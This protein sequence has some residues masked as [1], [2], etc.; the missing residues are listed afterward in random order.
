MFLDFAALAMTS[1]GAEFDPFDAAAREW[2]QTHAFEL[3]RGVT[4]TTLNE[5]RRTL[6]EGWEAGEGI[7][8]L[9]D[10]VREV[11]EEADRYRSF[12]IARTET[13]ATGNM[14]QLSVLRQTGIGYKTW[15]TSDDE[16]V[17]PVCGPLDGKTVRLDEEFA[18]GI[19][20]PPA[21][22][23]CRCTT[24][25][26]TELEKHLPGRHDQKTHG[27]HGYGR[28]SKV[29]LLP[30]EDA[31]ALGFKNVRSQKVVLRASIKAKILRN[32]PA[33]A[34]YL[35]R[36]GEVLTAWERQGRSP[37]H[38]G[39]FERYARL[40]GVWFTAVVQVAVEGS[41]YR[42]NFVVTFHRVDASKVA[43]RTRQGRIHP[44]GP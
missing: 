10:R 12:L 2:L 7:P 31:E 33:D 32:H 26:P 23:N 24:L 8:E 16:R 35:P 25:A 34:E 13:T 20:A 15:S 40:D 22:P 14:A 9:A 42:D 43:S 19:F 41:D 4:Q 37:T 36:I 28:P 21:H 11:F 30:R 1:L 5:L 39:R 29:S 18:P 44:P 6:T 27:R 38:A 17:C 3:V